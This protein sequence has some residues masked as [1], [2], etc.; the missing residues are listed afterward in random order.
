MLKY[1][2]PNCFRCD[3][4]QG[5]H[6]LRGK[7]FCRRCWLF[8][9][10]RDALLRQLRLPFVP[11]LCLVLSCGGEAF[12]S[13][14]PLELVDAGA[15]VVALPDAAGE[16][17]IRPEAGAVDV[18]GE[19]ERPEASPPACDLKPCECGGVHMAI[20]CDGPCPAGFEGLS[21]YCGN[22]KFGQSYDAGRCF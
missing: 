5:R 14:A 8:L 17:Y 10:R 11:F 21:C 6:H 2:Y 18:A 13:S 22:C 15:D 7:I 3:R 19:L 20:C 12:R 1:T 9:R 4:Y 16:L